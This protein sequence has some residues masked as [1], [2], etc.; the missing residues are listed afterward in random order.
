MKT[1][2]LFYSYSHKDE[3]HREDMEKALT[4]LRR[5]GLLADWYDRKIVPG[6][7]IAKSIESKMEKSDVVAFLLSQD[8]LASK[9]CTDEWNLAT[10][11]A[12]K[13]DKRLIPIILRE[14]AWTDFSNMSDM[15]ALPTDGKPIAEWGS[16]DAYWKDVYDG[17]KS[18]IN[19]ISNTFSPKSEFLESIN[20]IEFCSQSKET[21]TL[22]DV[23]VFPQL[24]RAK[25]DEE[26]QVTDSDKLIKLGNLLIRGEDQSGKT[27]LCA[28]LFTELTGNNEAVLLI[29]LEDLKSR[30]PNEHCFAEKYEEQLSGDYNRWKNQKNTVLIFDNL[31]NNRNVLGHVELAKELYSQLII[32]VNA[33]DY[34]AFFVDDTRFADFDNLRI[35]PLTHVKQEKLI[36]SWLKIRSDNDSDYKEDHVKVDAIERNINAIVLNNNI[37]PRYPFFVLSILQTHEMFMPTDIEITAYGHCYHTLII[38]HLIKSG[39]DRRDESINPCFNFASH[40]AF[41]I[42]RRKNTSPSISAAEYEEFKEKYLNDFIIRET[43]INRM[44]APSGI[45]KIADGR[46][47]FSLPYSYFFFLGRHLAATYKKN[48]SVVEEMIEKS[49]VRENTFSLIFAIHHAQSIDMLDDILLHTEC[50]IDNVE[51]AKLDKA[52]TALFK[53]LIGDVPKKILSDRSIEEERE[54]DR[55]HRDVEEAFEEPELEVSEDDYMNQIYKSEKNIEIL[56]QIVKNKTGSLDKAKI[57]EIVET[58]CDAGLR[59]VSLLLC[60]KEEIL[61]LTNFIEKRYEEKGGFITNKPESE[62]NRDLLK[63]VG[64]VHF[65]WTMIHVEKVVSS[66]NKPEL[67]QTLNDIRKRRD[68]PA[69]DIISFFHMLDVSSSFGEREKGELKKLFDKY[70][71]KDMFFVRR[72]LSIRTQHYFNTHRVKA[73]VKQSASSLLGIDFKP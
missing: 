53:E 66:I 67:K 9:A 4:L 68:T 37:L 73:S 64:L 72:V 69:F 26:E 33:T 6:Q 61:A 8:Y 1:I 49:F 45:I 16:S 17:I 40:L 28:H 29:D 47:S 43:L 20:A 34:R 41:F 11:L 59:L 38:A 12:E 18:V 48:Q 36:K 19:D 13:S 60:D 51:P 57:E 3:E 65:F 10:K 62:K 27:K 35:G 42:H 63:L 71:D 52:E 44:N 30:K 58:I 2:K 54:S 32:V 31:T 39:V 23:F 5:D 21:I 24:Y 15:L 70:G 7:S 55:G 22:D 56:S 25:D 14:C 46:V 50:S